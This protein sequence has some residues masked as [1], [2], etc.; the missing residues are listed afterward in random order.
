[1]PVPRRVVV[2]LVVGILAASQSGNIIRL[3][4]AHPVAIATWRLL[5]ASALLAPLAGRRLG[6]LRR[7]SRGEVGLLFAAGASLAAHFVVWIAAVQMTTVANAAVFFAINPVI[8]ASA[9]HLIFGERI[10]RKLFVAIGFGLLG[11]VALGLGD[12]TLD[13]EQLPGDLAA[14]GCSFLFTIYFLLGKRLRRSLS[15]VS[16]T[17]AVYGIAA[18]LSLGGMLALDLPLVDYGSRTWG[19]F[20]LMALVPTMIGHTSF[21]SA[22]RYI[23]AG[24]ISAATLSEPVLAGLVAIFAWGEEITG[25]GIVGYLLICAS[26]LVLVQDRR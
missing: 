26:V 5:I 21:N 20:L 12:L 2:F 8:T 24:R 1:M 11:V 15:T 6:E 4:D 3:G 14:L 9:G 17:S 23:D 22:L 13:P 19:C 7:L 18:L 25:Q 16:Y 10:T